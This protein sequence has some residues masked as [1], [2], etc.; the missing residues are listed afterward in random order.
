MLS[1]V[2]QIEFEEEVR[3]RANKQATAYQS[4]KYNVDDECLN[5][6]CVHSKALEN[7]QNGPRKLARTVENAWMAPGHVGWC[8]FKDEL[9]LGK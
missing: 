4:S 8:G 9:V 7:P 3:Q 2:I 5:L 1:E 6:K